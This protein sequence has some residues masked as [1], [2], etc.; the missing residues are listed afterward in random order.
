MVMKA[1]ASYR[2]KAR[3]RKMWLSNQYSTE[4]IAALLSLRIEHVEAIVKQVNDGTLRLQGGGAGTAGGNYGEGEDD[5]SLPRNID[6]GTAEGRVIAQ[7]QAD[8]RAAEERAKA[9]EAALAEVE[10]D[11]LVIED[12]DAE[13]EDESEED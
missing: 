1:G 7:L 11:E 2:D 5:A 3:V 9:A 6:Q 10:D 12:P 8:K 13:D 4:Q